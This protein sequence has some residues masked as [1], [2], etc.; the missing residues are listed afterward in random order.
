MKTLAN[1]KKERV[2]HSHLKIFTDDSVHSDGKV[3]CAFTIPEYQI[4]G[5]VRL[6]ED[7]SIFTADLFSNF[8]DSQFIAELQQPLKEVVILTDSKSALQALPLGSKSQQDM[9][10]EI[11]TLSWCLSYF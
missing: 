2:Y 8:Q 10:A 1:K 4:T 7:T 11:R 3:G 9:Q 5:K 6:N